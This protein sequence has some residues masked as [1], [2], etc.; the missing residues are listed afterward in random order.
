MAGASVTVKTHRQS[1]TP[2]S[3]GCPNVVAQPSD[4][5]QTKVCPATGLFEFDFTI[6]TGDIETACPGTASFLV[7]IDS[8]TIGSIA[9]PSSATPVLTI[10]PSIKLVELS[11]PSGAT[12]EN[13]PSTLTAIVKHSAGFALGTAVRVDIDKDSST[14]P[15]VLI[16]PTSDHQTK[17][18]TSSSSATLLPYE[19]TTTVQ[20]GSDGGEAYYAATASVVTSGIAGMQRARLLPC[21]DAPCLATCHIM[22]AKISSISFVDRFDDMTEMQINPIPSGSTHAWLKFTIRYWAEFDTTVNAK[23]TPPGPTPS[24]EATAVFTSGY[25]D[26]NGIVI[27][28]TTNP[29]GNLAEGTASAKWE[30]DISNSCTI[31]GA[32]TTRGILTQADLAFAP[33]SVEGVGITTLMASTPHVSYTERDAPDPASGFDSGFDSETAGGP[34]IPVVANETNRVYANVTN[35]PADLSSISL[36]AGNPSVLGVSPSSVTVNPQTVTLRGQSQGSTDNQAQYNG[37]VVGKMVADVLP[38]EG[39]TVAVW[40]VRQQGQPAPSRP[41]T[42][43]DNLSQYLNKIYRQAGVDGI[44]IKSFQSVTARYDINGNGMLDFGP[45]A[46]HPTNEQIVLHMAGYDD[47][48][49]LNIYFVH[50][51]PSPYA[52]VTVGSD[53]YIGD[54]HPSSTNWVTAHEV[55]HILGIAT[56]FDHPDRLSYGLDPGMNPTK[57]R[58]PE[59]LVVNYTAS[60]LP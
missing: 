2:A 15:G 26:K 11:F 21:I 32:L 56:Q 50:Q 44:V 10:E 13:I 5:T 60:Q 58:R 38:P 42:S 33:S 18:V 46:Q 14:P 20:L 6:T 31:L 23:V 24:C 8:T 30:M 39:I 34:F 40:I 48:V 3:P 43:A 55:E 49:A 57:I 7:W 9:P 16:T 54:T 47:S 17:Y 28:N 37:Q 35:P 12:S 1:T 22:T 45:D 53:T 29:F 27:K 52:G 4:D 51:L 41:P 59:W 25:A 36:S 19:F